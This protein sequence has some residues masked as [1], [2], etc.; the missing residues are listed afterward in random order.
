RDRLAARLA[1]ARGDDDSVRARRD[2]LAAEAGL[3]RAAID[4]ADRE[5]RARAAYRA[6]R[7]GVDDDLA[8]ALDPGL[9]EVAAA[10]GDGA[11]APGDAART[12]AGADADGTA[13]DSADPAAGGAAAGDRPGTT[14]TETR[15]DAEPGVPRTAHGAAP[16]P[17][18]SDAD[19]AD[20]A[21][22]ELPGAG[23]AEARAALARLRA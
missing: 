15:P 4:A 13:P 7:S 9:A 12:L 23:M 22:A 18:G 6:A 1:A 17:A 20:R 8:A 5:G 10:P 16:E 14:A 11:A 21:L 19:P 2:R 3:I